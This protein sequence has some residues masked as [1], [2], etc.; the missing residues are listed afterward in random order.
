MVDQVADVGNELASEF[1]WFTDR[2]LSVGVE[3][4]SVVATLDVLI[5][6][7]TVERGLGLSAMEAAVEVTIASLVAL[8]FEKT[9]AGKGS[10]WEPASRPQSAVI[11]SPFDWYSMSLSFVE[12]LGSDSYLSK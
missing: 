1:G 8:E 3:N 7:G 9:R 10:R 4:D 11:N 6:P 2:L 5:L 12:V